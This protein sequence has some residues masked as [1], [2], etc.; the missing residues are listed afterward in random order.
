MHEPNQSSAADVEELRG[1][2][3]R[4]S[5]TVHSQQDGLLQMEDALNQLGNRVGSLGNASP[6]LPNSSLSPP[7]PFSGEPS[8]CRGFL[9]QCSLIFELQ[10]AHFPTERAKVAYIIT[11]LKGKALDWAT[12][13]WTHRHPDCQTIERFMDALQ[14]VFDEGLTQR[15]ASSRLFTLTQGQRS[16]IDYAIEFRTLSAETGWEGEALVS[17]FYQGLRESLKDEMVNRDWGDDLDDIITL[18]TALDKRIQ[19][20]RRERR[21]LRLLQPNRAISPSRRTSQLP[22]PAPSPTSDQGEEPMQLGRSRLSLEERRR[23]FQQGL[24]LY[25][26][27]QD[28]QRL[29]C[30]ELQG[31]ANAHQGKGASW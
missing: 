30:P 29:Q 3:Q 8:A 20:R 24:C 16:V 2:V 27:S 9:T 25:C 19:E 6:S 17:A 26:G 12:A 22:L 23:R 28:H 18:A 10:P 13:L 14:R 11:R 1:H 4:L 31:K 7:P 5:V 15:Q 21:E